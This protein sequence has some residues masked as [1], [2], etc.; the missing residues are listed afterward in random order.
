MSNSSHL[1]IREVSEL[2][3][4]TTGTLYSYRH[5]NV[6]PPC[7]K[8]SGNKLLYPRADLELWM[9]GRRAATMRGSVF[10]GRPFKQ[11]PSYS[12]VSSIHPHP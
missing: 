8:I 1:S 9:A 11:P 3:G 7:F 6:G 4:L 5:H 2:T 12:P 10:P